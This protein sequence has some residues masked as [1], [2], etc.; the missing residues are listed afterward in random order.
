MGNV[1]GWGCRVKATAVA[2][3]NRIFGQEGAIFF[4]LGEGICF[5][6]GRGSYFLYTDRS[7]I[8]RVVYIL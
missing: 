1:P 7:F 8:T 6:G 2:D 3:L 5:E 4:L